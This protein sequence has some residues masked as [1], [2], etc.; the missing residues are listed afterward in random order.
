MLS[1]FVKYYLVCPFDLKKNK[2][3]V[4]SSQ[5][6][7]QLVTDVK[8]READAVALVMLY[9]LRHEGHPNNDVRGLINALRKRNVG[10]DYLKVGWISVYEICIMVFDG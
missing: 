5:R 7:Y 3:Y 8:V 2:V 1:L 6:I 10:D 4:Y 9:A